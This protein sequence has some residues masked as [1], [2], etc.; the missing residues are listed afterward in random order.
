MR[1]LKVADFAYYGIQVLRKVGLHKNLP[2]EN[3]GDI[4]RQ[5]AIN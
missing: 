3:G 5:F 1:E 2:N 4:D